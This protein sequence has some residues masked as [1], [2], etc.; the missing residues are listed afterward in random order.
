MSQLGGVGKSCLTG[1]SNALIQ[2]CFWRVRIYGWSRVLNSTIRSECLDRKL[3]SYDWRFLSKTNRGWCKFWCLLIEMLLTVSSGSTVYAGNVCR[4]LIITSLAKT[5][6]IIVWTQL[7]L[8]SSVS[9]DQFIIHVILLWHVSASPL[10]PI[11]PSSHLSTRLVIT[12]PTF[13]FHPFKPDIQSW[14]HLTKAS[15]NARTIH[16][17]RSRLSSSIQHNKSLKPK[18]TRRTTRANSTH[19]RRRERSHCHCWQQEWFG[20]W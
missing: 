5:D 16:E 18:R 17:I 1:R 7:G 11:S 3:W 20:R 13:K 9:F 15:G 6:D 12:T 2:T 14:S 19:K 4:S 8:N 10:C